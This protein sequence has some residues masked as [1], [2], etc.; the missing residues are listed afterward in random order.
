MGRCSADRDARDN[1]GTRPHNGVAVRGSAN[2]DAPVRAANR[3]AP[4]RAANRGAVRAANRG[5]S[6][7]SAGGAP[8]ER[9]RCRRCD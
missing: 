8:G 9:F 3:D 2:R 6:S 4:V 5:A 7:R 1:A